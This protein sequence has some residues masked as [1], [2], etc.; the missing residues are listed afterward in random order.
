ME[1]ALFLIGSLS[2]LLW[3]YLLL[4]PGAFWRADQQ[5]ACGGS[6][7]K[8][9]PGVA[10]IL[11][12]SD[13][14]ETIVETLPALLEQ[15]YPGDFHVIL[16]D[17]RGC[18]DTAEAALRVAQAAGATERLSVLTIDA[19]PAGWSRWAWAL[20]QAQEL[21]SST[22][23]GVDYLWLTQ[24]WIQHGYGSLRDLV[25]KAEEDRCSLVSLLP[26]STCETARDRLLAPAFA[27][28][29]QAFHPFRRV[30][31]PQDTAAVASAGCVLINIDVINAIGGFAAVKDAPV[32]ESSLA[33]IVKSVARQNGN[34]IWLGLGE[35]ST[36]VCDGGDGNALRD[37]ALTTAAAQPRPSLVGATTRTVGMTF[38]CLVPPVVF[39]WSLVTGLFLDIDQFLLTFLAVLFTSAA[40][41]AMAFAA[42]PTFQLY[43]Q[44]D[45]LTLLLPL[46][47]LAHVMVT[48]ALLP[49]LFDATPR[50]SGDKPGIIG[51]DGARSRPSA[52][53]VRRR[54]KVSSHAVHSSTTGHSL[55]QQ[56]LRS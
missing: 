45:W 24:P 28:F 11:A 26:M 8:R 16:V 51:K 36:A 38:A 31:D 23:P 25:A 12:V 10:A 52:G 53:K 18:D 29:L 20:A 47:A 33:R 56:I 21:A 13:G 34:G 14:A 35:D 42:R 9:W 7:P 17:D 32:L 30:N 40:W 46:A 2:L 5:L 37:V 3:C 55:R 54:P 1:I 43:G 44:E 48:V 49:N 19:P 15:A 4:L 39:F 27:F 6:D 22:P 50:R 41:G